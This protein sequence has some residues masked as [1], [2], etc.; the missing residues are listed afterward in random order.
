LTVF[1]LGDAETVKSVPMPVSATVCGLPGALSV[2]VKAPVRV[3]VAVGV[4]LTPILQLLPPARG[5]PTAQVVVPVSRA[6]SPL[7]AKSVKFN[8]ASP[9]FVT[10]RGWAALRLSTGCLPKSRLDGDTEMSSKG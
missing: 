8:V 5:V 10:E 6:K 2:I 9:V 7:T 3:P 1:E 4:K